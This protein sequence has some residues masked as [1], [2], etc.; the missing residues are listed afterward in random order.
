VYFTV[1][2]RPFPIG[3]HYDQVPDF[4]LYTETTPTNIQ[5]LVKSVPDFELQITETDQSRT[6]FIG[7]PM[8][9]LDPLPSFMSLD[10]STSPS[11]NFYYTPQSSWSLFCDVPARHIQHLTLTRPPST[12][13]TD[14]SYQGEVGRWVQVIKHKSHVGHNWS[15]APITAAEKTKTLFPVTVNEVHQ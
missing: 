8:V 15:T 1:L 14:T 4:S 11:P 12:N 5:S 13:Q 3:I 6:K 9:Q 7:L 2:R 10:W